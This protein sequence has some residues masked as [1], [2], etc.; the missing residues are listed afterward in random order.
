MRDKDLYARTLNI[1]RAME[2]EVVIGPGDAGEVGRRVLRSPGEEGQTT[3]ASRASLRTDV[4][5]CSPEVGPLYLEDGESVRLRAFM[6]RSIVEVFANDRQCL[7]LR[8]YPTRPDS[9]GVSAFP[10]GG[11]ARLVSLTAYR[12]ASVWPEF[13]RDQLRCR[14]VGR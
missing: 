13:E 4:T 6:D 8:A 11:D 3:D 9:T 10:Y 7:T 1:G 5:P 12:M 14:G 2:L